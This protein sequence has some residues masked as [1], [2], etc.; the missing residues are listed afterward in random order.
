MKVGIVTKDQQTVPSVNKNLLKRKI[1]KDICLEIIKVCQTTRK[2][3]SFSALSVNRN[4]LKGIL[5]ECTSSQ[6]IKK[7]LTKI[8]IKHFILTDSSTNVTKKTLKEHFNRNHKELEETMLEHSYYTYYS[9]RTIFYS[10]F[11]P[12]CVAL[13]IKL[14]WKQGAGGAAANRS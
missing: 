11:V 1:F 6:T 5:W 2:I 9:D 13:P 8:K 4:T 14:L 10:Y 7:S 3:R 12:S